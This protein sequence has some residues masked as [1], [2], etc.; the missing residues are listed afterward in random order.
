MYRGVLPFIAIQ[1]LLFLLILAM[2]GIAT[3]LPKQLF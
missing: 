1:L 2:P 3:W